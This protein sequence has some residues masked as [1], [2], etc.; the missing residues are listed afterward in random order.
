MNQFS[1]TDLE[2]AVRVFALLRQ[3]EKD[4]QRDIEPRKRC[5]P[6]SKPVKLR[7][8]KGNA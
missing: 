5:R 6:K 1:K 2:C 8:H 3:W 7:L 4:A